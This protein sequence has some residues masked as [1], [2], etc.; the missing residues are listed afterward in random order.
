MINLFS[1]SLLLL[2]N[3]PAR[4][5]YSIP[6]IVVISLV[7]GATRHERMKEIIENTLRT[8]VWVLAFMGLIF[9]AIWATGFFI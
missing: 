8:A 2:A 7:Y 5:W 4:I 9:L 1:L 6:L 3:A